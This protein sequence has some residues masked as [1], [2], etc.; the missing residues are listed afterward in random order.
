MITEPVPVSPHDTPKP[1]R[2][3]QS[4][5]SLN[6]AL[7]VRASLGAPGSVPE[8][9]RGGSGGSCPAWP[10]PVRCPGRAWRARTDLRGP[11][12]RQ[13]RHF[14]RWLERGQVIRRDPYLH[15]FRMCDPAAVAWLLRWDAHHQLTA[16]YR[17]AVTDATALLDP[18]QRRG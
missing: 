18:P 16:S 3:R 12:H 8:D 14:C 10:R 13:I 15:V 6:R 4:A 9:Q 11:P 17:A 7:G 2:S 1:R 5:R